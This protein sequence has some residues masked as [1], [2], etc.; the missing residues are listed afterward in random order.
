MASVQECQQA[1]ERLS[2]RLAGVDAQ[3]RKRH[4]VDRSVACTVS[5]LGVVWLAQLGDQG[6]A[7]LR[8]LDPGAARP[9]A[10]L[11][12]TVASDDLVA[13]TEGRLSFGSALATGRLKVDASVLDLLRLRSLL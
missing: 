13:L 10:Q 8:R 2:G 1:L 4:V 3:T 6:L 7:G 11:R 12:L 9:D 5:D